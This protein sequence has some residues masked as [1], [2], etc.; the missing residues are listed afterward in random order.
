MNNTLAVR[1]NEGIHFLCTDRITRCV[2]SSNY[3]WFYFLDKLPLLVSRTMGAY[4]A[5]LPENDFIRINRTVIIHRQSIE[6]ISTKGAVL[7]KDG[8]CL[9]ISRRRRNYVYQLLMSA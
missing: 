6:K 3:T 1:T 2:A 9:Q 5:Q 8:T 4:V 7:L